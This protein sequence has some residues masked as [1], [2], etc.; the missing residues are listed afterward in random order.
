MITK[1]ILERHHA[2]LEIKANEQMGSTFRILF[3]VIMN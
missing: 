1:Q 2:F 3:P